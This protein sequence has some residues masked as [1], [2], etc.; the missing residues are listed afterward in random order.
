[1]HSQHQFKSPVLFNDKTSLAFI[2][3]IKDLIKGYQNKVEGLHAQPGLPVHI[4]TTLLNNYRSFLDI[5]LES[6]YARY[7]L[8]YLDMRAV[9]PERPVYAAIIDILKEID[10]LN[11]EGK[12]SFIH[13]L[14]STYNDIKQKQPA[15]QQ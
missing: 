3:N 4:K 12:V 5:C 1:M 6:L 14:L 15:C 9:E 10:S 11:H 13:Y 2:S 8:E 7:L